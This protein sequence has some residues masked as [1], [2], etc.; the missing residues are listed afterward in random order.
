MVTYARGE[1]I[2]SATGLM[3]PGLVVDGTVRL[4]VR[5]A[6]GREATVRTAGRGVTFGLV[7][8]FDPPRSILKVER[9]VLAGLNP[10]CAMFDRSTLLRLSGLH[11][12]LALELARSLAESASILTD[13]AG[14]FAFMTVRQRLAGHLLDIAG[15]ETGGRP[16]AFITQQEL[17]NAI[18]SVREVVA[19]TLHDLREAGLRAVSPGRIEVL[20]QGALTATAFG[21]T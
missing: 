7:S 4:I 5:A 1:T 18:G 9:G 8:L 16:V 17:A 14:Q 11:G 19:R 20:D 12:E 21:A 13:A 15:E 6:D 3:T 2:I 10:T